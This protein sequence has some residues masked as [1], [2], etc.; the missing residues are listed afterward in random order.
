MRKA[1]VVSICS[2]NFWTKRFQWNSHNTNLENTIKNPWYLIFDIQT[3]YTGANVVAH[4]DTQ[5]QTTTV[6][7]AAHARWGLITETDTLNDIIR[8]TCTVGYYNEDSIRKQFIRC[9][10]LFKRHSN[11]DVHLWEL[12]WPDTC[13]LRCSKTVYDTVTHSWLISTRNCHVCI[14]DVILCLLN[15]NIFHELQLRQ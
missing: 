15:G 7:P 4:T 10:Y 3:R 1:E 14:F 9:M 8:T 13:K 12:E 5:T 11:K 2:Q 6:T